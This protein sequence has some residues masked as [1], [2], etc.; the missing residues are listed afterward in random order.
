[1][2]IQIVMQAIFKLTGLNA[3]IKREGLNIAV[4]IKSSSNKAK[5]KCIGINDLRKNIIKAAI[6]IS[7]I[8]AIMEIVSAKNGKLCAFTMANSVSLNQI[9]FGAK[10]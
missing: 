5:A 1:M 9:N 10:P 6:N 3:S 2:I 8:P 4:S 7:N